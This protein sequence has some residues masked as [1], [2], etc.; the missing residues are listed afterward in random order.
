MTDFNRFDITFLRDSFLKAE[1]FN[2]LIIDNFLDTDYLND[3]LVEVQGY[4]KM[5]DDEY[6]AREIDN[7]VQSG[8]IGISDYNM[9]G[10]KVKQFF[11]FTRSTEM[12]NFISNITGIED[13]QDDP[14]LYGGGIHRTTTG[15]RLEIHADFNIHPRTG[16]HR[17]INIL[18][19]LNKDW[20]PHYNGELELWDQTM[21]KCCLK[22]PPVFNRMVI[23]R[24]T[25][26]AYHG[27]PQIWAAPKNIPRL[28]FALYYYTDDRP[29]HEKSNRHMALWQT[30]PNAN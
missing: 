7:H 10:P 6:E 8:K 12:I 28:S 5:M 4:E 19:Y 18:L 11:D 14:S 13:I 22:I 25:D 1:P 30:R 29:E 3:I 15:G 21:S 24:I 9:F 2:Y 27:H 20:N 26:T 16:K 17:R 23:F